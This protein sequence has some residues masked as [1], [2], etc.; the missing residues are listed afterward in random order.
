LF[1]NACKVANSP[2]ARFAVVRHRSC[3]LVYY[4]CT[5]TLAQHR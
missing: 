5:Q 1:K 3:G 4:W 2:L